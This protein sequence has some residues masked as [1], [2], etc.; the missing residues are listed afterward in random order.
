MSSHA[1]FLSCFGITLLSA[2]MDSRFPNWLTM[3]NVVLGLLSIATAAAIQR[4]FNRQRDRHS[5]GED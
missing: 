3:I 4:N 2:A 1:L 5:R